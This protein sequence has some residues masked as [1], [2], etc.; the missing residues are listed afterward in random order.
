MRRLKSSLESDGQNAIGSNLFATLGKYV[1]HQD[2][3]LLTQGLA[4]LFATCKGFRQDFL[5]LLQKQSSTRTTPVSGEWTVRTQVS[6]RLQGGKRIVADLHIAQRIGRRPKTF[7]IEVKLDSVLGRSQA[8]NY[9]KLIRKH[10]RDSVIQLVVLTQR[11]IDPQEL[12]LPSDSIMLTWADVDH[13]LTRP[14]KRSALERLLCVQYHEFLLSKGVYMSKPIRNEGSFKKKLE[15]LNDFIVHRKDSSNWDNLEIATTAMLRLRRLSQFGW[16]SL[17]KRGCS[18]YSMMLLN[19]DSAGNPYVDLQVGYYRT[20][21]GI[22]LTEVTL[23]FRLNLK[24]GTL[25]ID[26]FRRVRGVGKEW[27]K[28]PIAEF[29]SRET[30]KI[31]AASL[32]ESQ[33][34]LRKELENSLSKYSKLLGL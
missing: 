14:G 30:A 10:S 1:E 2:E 32:P 17:T 6:Y 28:N 16:G 4:A 34:L 7:L 9:N 18:P 19:E 21:R 11:Q 3:N 22:K 8:S 24:R 27:L 29:S 12:D 26:I 20:P 33:K 5:N 31:F 23:A 15:R 25:T 13:L